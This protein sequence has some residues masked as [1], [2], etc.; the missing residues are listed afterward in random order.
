MEFWDKNH[1]ESR[2]FP[3]VENN[4]NNDE[5]SSM[6]DSNNVLDT[7]PLL[8]ML[9][10]LEDRSFVKVVEQEAG[11]VSYS[12]IQMQGEENPFNKTFLLLVLDGA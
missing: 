1:N 2:Y 12:F 5:S 6:N 3:N 10:L 9:V 7:S 11:V 4:Y 8:E